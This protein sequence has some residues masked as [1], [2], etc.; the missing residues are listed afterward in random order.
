VSKVLSTVMNGLFGINPTNKRA[1]NLRKKS[2]NT[3][4]LNGM[5]TSNKIRNSSIIVRI[6]PVPVSYVAAIF[7]AIFIDPRRHVIFAKRSI[8]ADP[9]SNNHIN[10]E[11]GQILKKRHRICQKQ[12]NV[13]IRSKKS[14]FRV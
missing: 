4:I 10:R 1:L 7:N 11:M 5:Y 9:G 2:K 3:R 13:F 12:H 8:Y 14:Y 6:V